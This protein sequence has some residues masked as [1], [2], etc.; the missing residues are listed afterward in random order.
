MRA[1]RARELG[2]APPIPTCKVCGKKLK[3]GAG[4]DKAYEACLCWE[5]WK[6]SEEGKVDRRRFNLRSDNW[7]VGYVVKCADGQGRF[8]ASARAAVSAARTIG[9]DCLIA[10]VW[11]DGLVT[12]HP[13]L[14]SKNCS[15]L[16][17]EDGDP[18]I[19]DAEW[20]HD[21]VPESKR[22]WFEV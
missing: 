1:K 7:A 13:G 19:E 8:L 21:Q 9:R 20:F 15:G 5:H 2:L 10:C 6:L 11:R 18:I 4:S 14:T 3:K 16:K 12:V 22:T 17:P